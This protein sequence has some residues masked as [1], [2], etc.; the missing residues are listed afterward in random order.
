MAH[1]QH[2]I[3]LEA[4]TRTVLG[5]KVRALRSSGYIPAVL[6]GKGQEA[7][8]LQVPIKNFHKALKEAGESTLVYVNVDGKSYP[9]IIHDV[10]RDPVKDDVIHADFYKVSLTEKIKTKVPVVFEGESLAVK[11]LAGIFVRNVNELEVEALPQNLPHE[12]SISISSLK[13]FGDQILVKDIKFGSDI[14][15]VADEDTILATIQEPKSQEEL[16]AELAAPTAGVEDVEIV[17]KKKEEVPAEE[18]EA[19]AAPAETK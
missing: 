11:D 18:G 7:L 14:K 4:Q 1:A 12:I 16:D 15:L 3:E 5:A 17:E 10:A 6:Y 9:T 2:K 13:N 19:P 8:N